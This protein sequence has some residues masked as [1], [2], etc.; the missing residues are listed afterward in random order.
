MV[1]LSKIAWVR[2]KANHRTERPL[3]VK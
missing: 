2:I 3:C 1:Q